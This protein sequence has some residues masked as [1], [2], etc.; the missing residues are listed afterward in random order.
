MEVP[1]VCGQ[2]FRFREYHICLFRRVLWIRCVQIQ[3]FEASYGPHHCLVSPAV[4]LLLIL[5]RKFLSKLFEQ[6]CG[7]ETVEAFCWK[8][9]PIRAYFLQELNDK[10]DKDDIK[11]KLVG[12]DPVKQSA[13]P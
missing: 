10:D 8:F 5:W 13:R 3:S 2:N 12:V 6:M 1:V 4:G 11:Y 7:S 9:L